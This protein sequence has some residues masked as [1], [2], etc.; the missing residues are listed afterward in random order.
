MQLYG[1]AVVFK[2]RNLLEDHE[3]LDLASGPPVSAH[4]TSPRSKRTQLLDSIELEDRSKLSGQH[5]KVPNLDFAASAKATG[6]LSKDAKPKKKSIPNPKSPSPPMSD[7]PRTPVPNINTAVNKLINE[8][9]DGRLKS[10]ALTAKRVDTKIDTSPAAEISKMTVDELLAALEQHDAL[11]LTVTH[12]TLEEEETYVRRHVALRKELQNLI[13]TRKLVPASSVS[14]AAHTIRQLIALMTPN[15][16]IRPHI[17]TKPKRSDSRIFIRLVDFDRSLL[18]P[19]APGT[20]LST[21]AKASKAESGDLPVRDLVLRS[22][23]VRSVLEVQQS[24]INFGQCDKGEAKSKTIVIQNKSDCIGLF[25]LRTSG[26]IASGDLKLGLG[27]LGVIAAFGRKEIENFN[28]VP[29]LGGNYQETLT[30]NNVLDSF[31]DQ[32]IAIKAV[33]RRQP[34]LAVEPGSIDF[35]AVEPRTMSSGKWTD[36]KHF[37]LT[38]TSKVERTFVLEVQSSTDNSNSAQVSLSRDDTGGGT[39]LSKGEE[40]EVETILQK[41]KGAQRKGKKDKIVKYEARLGELGVTPPNTASPTASTVSNATSDVPDDQPDTSQDTETRSDG[42][43]GIAT[44]VEPK[45]PQFTSTLHIVLQPNEKTKIVVD[46]VPTLTLAHGPFETLVKVYDRK[47]TD[48][49]ISIPLTASFG[50]TKHSPALEVLSTPFII[51]INA[52]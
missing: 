40:E 17:T 30:V 45:C 12:T 16:S 33:V 49:T 18:F 9:S 8:A 39:A 27:R 5:P 31:N 48:E 46:L 38:N 3:Y 34:A 2:D 37:L 43:S 1:N 52:G 10:P 26:S 15:G 50:D 13:S 11:R 35:G 19:S 24:S 7:T 44:P 32:S 41:L 25:R 4:R 6:L 29:S 22:S 28:F 47:N 42:P 36:A 21:A 23:C 14:V 51:Y 20:P